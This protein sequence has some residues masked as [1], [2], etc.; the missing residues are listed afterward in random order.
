MKFNILLLVSALTAS[1]IAAP[2]STYTVH[3]RRSAQSASKRVKRDEH[4]IVV[5]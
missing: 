1:V 3:E 4:L 2:A 5:Q